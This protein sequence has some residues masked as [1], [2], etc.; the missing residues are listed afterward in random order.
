MNERD[1]KL[2]LVLY[3][4]KSITKASGVLHITQPALSARLRMVEEFFGVQIVVRGK[5]G[6]QFTAEGEYLV[7]KARDVLMELDRVRDVLG[8]MRNMIAGTLR[9]GASHFFTRYILPTLLK[10]FKALYP[11]VEFRVQT[12][13]SN[14]LVQQVLRNDLH[15]AFI[16][17]DHG[18]SGI[19]RLLFTEHLL[20]ASHDAFSIEDMPRL[21]QIHHTNDQSNQMLINNWW[22][23]HF[24]VP[25]QIGMMVDHVD[26][27]LEMIKKG[28]GYGFLPSRIVQRVD[29]LHTKKMRY[30]SGKLL[31]RSTWMI[32]KE[33]TANLR[34]IQEFFNMVADVDFS[35]PEYI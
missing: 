8:G 33:E 23:E 15:L 25:P 30:R 16:R 12:G 24:N 22:V 29:G 20:I 32:F 11:S 14:D 28:L 10:N 1:W 31:E 5:K 35:A 2:L 7:R 4:Q 17:E 19:K 21:P 18:W 34:L 26:T 9:I 3:E 27:C 13:W 6:V